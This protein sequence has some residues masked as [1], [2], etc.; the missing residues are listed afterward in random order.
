[1]LGVG[2]AIMRRRFFDLK[3]LVSYMISVSDL[4]RGKA[5]KIIEEVANRKEHYIIIKNNKPQAVIIPI[6]Q[7]DEL[8]EAQE[9]LELLQLAIERMKNL[10]EEDLI[11]FDEALKEA[12]LNEKELEQYIDLVEIE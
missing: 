1:M 6:D 8:M 10:K 5:S 3:D 2:D 9:E 7:Y 11:P 12:S 4:G